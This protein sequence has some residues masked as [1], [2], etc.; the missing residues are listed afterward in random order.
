[1]FGARYFGGRHFGK[2]YFGKRGFSAPA[3]DGIYLGPRYFGRR[4]FNQQFPEVDSAYAGARYFGNRYF[5]SRYF[6]SNLA[7]FPEA[8][9]QTQGLSGAGVGA[10]SSVTLIYGSDLALVVTSGLA[11]Q[12]APTID[13]SLSFDSEDWSFTPPLEITG[14]VG[15]GT[16]AGDLV[17]PEATTGGAGRHFG[18]R[19]FGARFFGPRYWGTLVGWNLE[20]TQGVSGLGEPLISAGIG[21]D[22]SFVPTADYAAI[23]T[24]ILT[25]DLSFAEPQVI[26]T[27]A[28][29]KPP[30]RRGLERYLVIINGK[31]HFGT[32]DEIERL[33]ET[34]ATEQAE[35]PKKRRAKIVVKPAE[36][37]ATVTQ[38]DRIEAAEVQADARQM[39]EDLYRKAVEE[40]ERQEE[41]DLLGLL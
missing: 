5:G 13:A 18:Y 38:E 17:F 19:Y 24:G 1:M 7:S 32:R 2:R 4:Y 8:I 37:V 34:V 30:G 10:F 9:T 22:V 3:V 25:A 31:K 26:T 41:E 39:Y 16:L 36:P 28:P 14:G 15:V 20:Q 33:I 40:L 23:G 21:L 27:G 6:G 12:G 29:G 35:K 11:G